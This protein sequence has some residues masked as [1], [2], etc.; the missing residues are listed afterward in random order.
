[1]RYEELPGHP[2]VVAASV[3]P[4]RTSAH[5]L[6]SLLDSGERARAGA[7]V[8]TPDA[9]RYVVAHVL[10]RIVLGAYVDER[11]DRLVFG[12]HPCAGCEGPHGKPYLA[13]HDGVH[14]S[15]SHAGDRVLVALAPVPVGVDV[16]T[17]PADGLVHD[18]RSALHPREQ[19][20]LASLPASA[21]AGA[22][23]RCWARK[24]AVLKATGVA[25]TRGAAEPYVGT[26][27]D[28]APVS[29]LR[30]DDVLLTD[31]HVA[32]VAVGVALPADRAQVARAPVSA[33][34]A[35][36]RDSTRSR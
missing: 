1:M 25:L 35:I 31:G 11:P 7:F 22:F 33:T 6:A 16:E 19:R 12:R 4:N 23:A 27:L 28:P 8:R 9:D 15:L 29:G 34:A 10:L 20:E 14:F 3:Y 18:V 13:G 5:A 2:G 30:L 17:V 36:R 24:E 21:R 32:A 26:A